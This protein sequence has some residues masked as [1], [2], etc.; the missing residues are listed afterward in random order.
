[1]FYFLLFFFMKKLKLNVKK[2][3]KKVS[4]YLLRP[5]FLNLKKLGTQRSFIKKIKKN[6][7]HKSTRFKFIA[8]NYGKL[9]KGHINMVQMLLRRKVKKR[10][11]V[12]TLFYPFLPLTK[13]PL[14]VR[15]GKGKGK[16]FSWF[17]FAKPG[18][19][20]FELSG[21]HNKILVK[22]TFSDINKRLPIKGS[23]CQFKKF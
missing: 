21:R 13:K 22:K 17:Y 11:K 20:L 8:K 18:K 16:V 2:N 4:S 5:K 6:R 15:M 14:Q 9:K 23:V 3:K 19:S 1:M 7:G 10:I 12:R